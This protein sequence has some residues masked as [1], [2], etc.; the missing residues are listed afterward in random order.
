ME[1]AVA[2][3]FEA[4]GILWDVSAFFDSIELADLVEFGLDM[5]FPP[6]ELN[7]SLQVHAGARAFKEGPYISEFVQPS[8]KSIL[9]GCGRSIQFTR[10]ILYDILSDMHQKFRPVQIQTFVDDIAQTHTGPQEII[11]KAGVEQADFLVKRL[12]AAGFTIAGKSAIV[13]S[14]P[15]LAKKLQTE[16]KAT[17]IEVQVQTGGRNVR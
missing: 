12:Q 4:A 16:L 2:Q 8:G 1:A 10:C 3:N 14:T 5:D 17:C 13:A 6:W 9:A 7:L 15:A 11:E